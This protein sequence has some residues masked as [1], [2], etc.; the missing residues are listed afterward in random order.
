MTRI[1]ITGGIGSGKSV[2]A[3]LLSV[4]GIPVYIADDEGKKLADTS[5]AIRERLVRLFGPEI[6]TGGGLNR[7][8]LARAI[9]GNKELLLQVDRII[10][11]E[12][13]RHF[14]AWS[15]RLPVDCC[16]IESAILFESG[17]DRI[18]DVKLL[19][20]A[21]LE[22]RIR[23]ALQRGNLTEEDLRK[24][25]ANQIPDEE[26]KP[27]A[28]YVVTNDGRKPLLPQVAEFLREFKTRQEGKPSP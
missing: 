25:I 8:L 19:V 9:F 12:V 3:Q 4:H 2:V 26:K 10:H 13:N 28:D 6:Y 17:F 1:G 11:P 24:R 14:L 16:A 18:V 27:R 7:P 23:R 21:P 5:P 15:G 22:I 20:Y